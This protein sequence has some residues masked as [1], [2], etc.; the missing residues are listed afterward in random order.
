MH[1]TALHYAAALAHNGTAIE[2]EIPQTGP[3]QVNVPGGSG[4]GGGGVTLQGFTTLDGFLN[5]HLI[6]P[7]DP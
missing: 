2:D 4:G 3:G 1:C 6:P 5:K 7:I